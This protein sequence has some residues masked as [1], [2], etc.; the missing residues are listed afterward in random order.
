MGAKKDYLRMD[1]LSSLMNLALKFM[2][3]C[4]C[5]ILIAALRLSRCGK[6]GFLFV[7]MLGLLI[8]VASL[9]EHKL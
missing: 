1:S 2:Y 3:F 5:C 6:W 4:L 7:A 9:V 8:P